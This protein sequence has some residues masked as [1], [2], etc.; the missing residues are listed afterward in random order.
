MRKF[1][2]RGKGICLERSCIDILYYIYIQ[3][4]YGS[5]NILTQECAR[6]CIVCK[7]KYFFY[8]V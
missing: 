8:V 4:L 5:K 1:Y 6:L 7:I 2:F 3:V